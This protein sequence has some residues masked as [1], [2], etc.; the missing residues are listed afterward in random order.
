MKIRHFGLLATVAATTMTDSFAAP[1]VVFKVSDCKLAEKPLETKPAREM[2]GKVVVDELEAHSPVGDEQWVVNG[3]GPK[4]PFIMA[5]HLS[6]AEHRPL[7]I[8][9]D[10]IWQLLIQQAANQVHAKPED[11]RKLFAKHEY[12]KRTL[13][14]QRDEFT[15]GNPNNNWAGVISELEG[16]VLNNVPDS[17]A[18]SFGHRFST[19]SPTEIAS[20]RVTLL[21]AASNYYD[22]HMGSWCG[23][24]R[25]ELHGTAADWR[26]IQSNAPKLKAF[27]M[28]RRLKALEPVFAE[29]VAS[30]EG[31][32]NPAFWKSFYKYASESGGP[33]VSGW[34]NLFFMPA[35]YDALLDA[36]LKDGFSWTAEPPPAKHKHDP[37]HFAIRLPIRSYRLD[38]TT[39]VDFIWDYQG[40][41]KPMFIKAGFMGVEQDPKT[42]TLKPAMGWQVIHTKC[43]AEERA[44]IDYL[45]RLQTLSYSSCSA[46]SD[47]IGYDA[48]EGSVVMS[49]KKRELYTDPRMWK[50][51]IPLMHN[52][53]YVDLDCVLELVED[54]KDQDEICKAFLSAKSVK[55]IEI[56]I[57]GNKSRLNMLRSR[58][59]WEVRLP[60]KR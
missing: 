28:D 11:Y 42:G 30:A 38:G 50:K 20:R 56:G 40:E 46:I 15:L 7:A 34:I 39:A 55:I 45:S 18:A 19:S 37:R 44:A 53:K 27:N 26:W 49:A 9:P 22:F 12:G 52:L 29:L 1:P 4:H 16:M 2:L 54:S 5:A 57:Y 14:I 3:R 58:K 33:V 43:T 21:N 35:N 36:V 41:T 47:V 60:K 48:Q 23:I 10:M 13:S 24:P 17:P 25:I 51:A 31:K 6:F 32:A 8:S 59:D